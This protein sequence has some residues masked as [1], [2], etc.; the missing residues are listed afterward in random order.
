MDQYCSAGPQ[1][2]SSIGRS[3]PAQRLACLLVVAWLALLPSLG[4]GQERERLSIEA[5]SPV[6]VYADHVQNLEQEK[7]L[8]AEGNVQL[9]QGD[10]RLESDRMEVNTETGEAVASGRVVLFDGRDRLTGSRIEYNLRS[11]TGIVYQAEAAAE[12]HFF[13]QGN[14]MDRVGD[15]AYRIQGGV[16]T[17]C[18]DETPAWSVRLG[19]ATAYLDDYM[20]GTNA[21][22]WVW[23]VPLVPFIPFFATSLRKDRHTGLLT[24]TFGSSNEKGFFI[25][26]PI[27]IVLGDS[28][29]LVLSPA[30]F[31]KRGP[32]IGGT[33][34]YVRTEGS[35]GEL[36]GFYLHDDEESP[37]H[38]ANRWI[39]SLRHEEDITPRLVFKADVARVSDDK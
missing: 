35:R 11:G 19:K 17:T 9:E 16:F 25:R 34:R 39:A 38:G 7:L 6:T 30:C 20:W 1:A 37:D 26:Q 8:L 10:V 4:W 15:K 36:D 33:Y 2:T 5:G 21:S 18:E 31:T 3:V 13:F 28:Q 29:D 32:G 23:K 24:P 22:F 14:S 27:Y 12:P